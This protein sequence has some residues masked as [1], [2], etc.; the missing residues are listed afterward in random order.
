VGGDAAKKRGAKRKPSKA[1]PRRIEIIPVNET[2]KQCSCG[3]CKTVIRYEIKEL[4]H[5]QPPVLETLEQRREV[6]ACPR[7][8]EGEIITAPAPL[9]VLPKI[10]ATEEFLSFLVVSKLEDRQ[11]LYHLEKQMRARYGVDCARQTM[12][13]WVIDLRFSVQ[14]L[15]NLLKDKRRDGVI[16]KYTTISLDYGKK[17]IKVI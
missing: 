2:D 15:Y 7:G 16:D 12:A 5:Y 11:P 4:V 3:A 6:V 14:P 13:R 1:L 8:C 10:N 9:H 17:E